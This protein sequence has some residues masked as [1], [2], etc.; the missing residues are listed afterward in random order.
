MLLFIY[1]L[2][3]YIYIEIER[4]RERERERDTIY[5]Y[6]CIHVNPIYV[7]TRVVSR[8][9]LEPNHDGFGITHPRPRVGSAH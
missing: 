2:Y 8:V 9:T 7:W 5:I 3:R 6:I 4:K 1:M